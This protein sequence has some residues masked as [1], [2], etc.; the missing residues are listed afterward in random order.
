MKAKRHATILDLIHSQPVETQDELLMLLSEKGL[1]VTQATISRDIKELRLVKTLTPDG[2]YHY[3]EQT[4][5][6]QNEMSEK[7]FM[8]F[9][10][11]VKE[12]DY[13]GNMLVIK[14]YTGMANAVCAA[15]D[16][17]HWNGVVGTL[18]GDDTI[19]AV[20]RDEKSAFEMMGQLR[21]SLS[22]AEMQ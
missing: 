6:P 21:K 20:M 3:T 15:L 7:F 22:E 11:S 5:K 16:M 9:S 18:A 14:C 4:A 19:F 13:A 17:M 2:K 10:S 8:I 12:L 1:Q